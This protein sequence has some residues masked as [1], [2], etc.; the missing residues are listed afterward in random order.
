MLRPRQLT[1]PLIF[2]AFSCAATPEPTALDVAVEETGVDGPLGTIPDELKL[3]GFAQNG[4]AVRPGAPTEVWSADNAWADRDTPAARA[5]GIAWPA[6]SGLDWEEKYERWIASMEKIARRGSGSTFAVPT[7]YGTRT[8]EAPT[9]EC[10]EVAVFLRITFASWY[11]L[12]FYLQ[13]WDA[14][15]RKPLFAGHFGFVYPDGARAGRFPLFRDA[16]RDH[17]RTWREGQPWPSDARLRGM[18]LGNDDGNPFLGEG[19]GAGAY[20]DELFLNKRVGYFSRL[21]LLYFGSVNLADGANMFHVRPEAIRAGDTLLERWQ[22]RGIGHTLPVMRVAEPAPGRFAVDV[23][24]GSMPRRQPIW[25]DPAS[26]RHYFSIDYTGGPGMASDGT[27]YAKLGGGLRRWRTAIFREGRWRNEVAL[28]DREAMIPDGDLE[29]IAARPAR[30]EEILAEVSPEEQRNAALAEI[31][32]TRMHLRAHP[33]SCS[34][35][36]AREDAFGRLYEV[37]REY[38]AQEPA[39]VDAAHRRLEDYV[40]GELEYVRSRTCCW[41][42]TTD[43]MGELILDY[44]AREQERAAASMTCT[45]PTVFRARPDG[46]ELWRNHAASLGREAQWLG[47]SE[48]EPCAQR[49]VPEDAETGRTGTAWCELAPP[50]VS[51]PAGDGCD[52][53]PRNDTRETATP[54]TPTAPLDARICAGDEDWYH[55]EPGRVTITFTHASGD[56]D[57]T[58]HD[59]TGTRTGGST[60]TSD[61]EELTVTTPTWIRVFGYSGASN[62]YRIALD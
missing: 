3:D 38:F 32:R 21:A 1:I 17:E 5:A 51:P 47:W 16:Y 54:L 49:D 20:F 43:A 23:A 53:D 62:T 60:G 26:S 57:M 50:D 18:R 48:D 15:A 2:T 4:P 9:L 40:F 22:K 34:A 44:A 37:M 10:A 59:A 33:A 12:P 28:A 29:A 55:V 11:H 19:L 42:G 39:E 41:N 7:P 56:L 8:F 13:G 14:D 24:T 58:A 25:S 31:E 27:P 35:R 6:D 61:T 36:T 46:Y 30:F 52:P 45:A